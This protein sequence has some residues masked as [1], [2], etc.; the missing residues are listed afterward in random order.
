MIHKIKRQENQVPRQKIK[1]RI[2]ACDIT[3]TGSEPGNE[4]SQR[5]MDTMENSEATKENGQW[6]NGHE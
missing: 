3:G 4:S 5:D 2:V 6:S 1:S